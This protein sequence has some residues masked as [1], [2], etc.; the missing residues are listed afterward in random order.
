MAAARGEI[1]LQLGRWNA[2]DNSAL[3]LLTPLVYDQLR[4]LATRL[5]HRE[6]GRDLQPT[7]L[8][9]EL[10]VEFLKSKSLDLQDR[11]HFF[12]LSARVMRQILIRQAREL[13]AEKRGSGQ[14]P[15]PLESELA[16][17]G[18][19]G[20]PDAYDLNAAMDELGQLDEDSLRTVEL[21][22]I[23][24]FTAEE[25]ASL[26]GVSKPTVDRRSRFALAW[27]RDRLHPEC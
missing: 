27:L 4:T 9:D 12:A 1:T 23:F 17:T 24:G 11:G 22:H 13:N 2:G 25:T 19:D 7:E 10:F 5:L 26:L 20:H 18:G 6:T 21:R 14:R 8:V 3:D 16:W 15:L